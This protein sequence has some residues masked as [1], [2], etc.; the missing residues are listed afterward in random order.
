[1]GEAASALLGQR[2]QRESNMEPKLCPTSRTAKRASV[3]KCVT[4][5]IRAR[6]AG[7]RCLP[8]REQSAEHPQVRHAA[9]AAASASSRDWTSSAPRPALRPAKSS[10]ST[11]RAACP[12][13]VTRRR[14]QY[15]S[16]QGYA[17]SPS[18]DASAARRRKAARNVSSAA[19]CVSVRGAAPASRCH[20]RAR[21]TRARRHVT[22][23]SGV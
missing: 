12:P 15:R 21:I 14:A 17:T 5:R 10:A 11:A 23:V 8:A 16:V 4:R 6:H 19:P 9:A 13:R 18:A 22:R 2:A 3:R 20:A 1:M 7:L